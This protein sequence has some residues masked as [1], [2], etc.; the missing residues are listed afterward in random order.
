LDSSDMR[1]VA[2]QWEYIDHGAMPPG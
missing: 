2:F 1:F